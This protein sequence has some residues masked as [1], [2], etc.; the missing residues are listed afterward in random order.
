MS[1]TLAKFSPPQPTGIFPRKRLFSRLDIG[2]DHP[3]VW[4]EGPPGA[5][6]TVLLA[7]YLEEKAQA[8]LWFRLEKEDRDP[9]RFF[10]YLDRAAR[11]LP[12]PPVL[13]SPPPV[14]EAERE[15]FARA[16]L[17]QLF[18][19]LPEGAAVV[20]DNF[21]ELEEEAP[22]VPLL[23]GA[24]EE[25]PRGRTVFVLS[26][27]P[28]PRHFA[29]AQALRQL[30][31]I[32][33]DELALSPEETR[34]LAEVLGHPGLT[35]AEVTA[36]HEV[37]RGW[38]AGQVL[39]LEH[40]ADR[41]PDPEQPELPQPLFDFFF[42]EIF[43]SAPE[44]DRALLLETA[45]LPFLDPAL[46]AG[47]CGRTGGADR[48]P[49]LPTR[50]RFLQPLGANRYELH[51]L[52]RRFL[53]S[54]N[55]RDR[56]AA[57]LARLRK[58]AGDLLAEAGEAD[59]AADLLR[60][61]GDW[62]GLAGLVRREAPLLLGQGRHRTLSEWLLALPDRVR[63]ADPW[64][65][66]WL[67][68]ARS[69][70]Q[71]ETAI[72]DLESAYAG[73]EA[74]EDPTGLYFAWSEI[75]TAHAFYGTD[76]A[77]LDR[78][79]DELA[80]L[81][82]RYPEIPDAETELR[83]AAGA[84]TALSWH[85]PDPA[86]IR[87]WEERIVAAIHSGP[88]SGQALMAA[89]QIAVYHAT[90]GNVGRAA[91]LTD[92]I[93]QRASAPDTPVMLGIGADLL[94]AILAQYGTDT[95]AWMRAAERGL[96]RGSEAGIRG[97][98]PA[99]RSLAVYA[100]LN[101]GDSA[102]ATSHLA[103]FLAIVDQVPMAD[104]AH[105]HELKAWV[106]LAEGHTAEA[107]EQARLAETL[108]ERTGMPFGEAFIHLARAH[109]HGALGDFGSAKTQADRARD[110]AEYMDS[111]MLRQA[112][113]L[114]QAYLAHRRGDAATRRDALARA[115]E[116]GARHGFANSALAF[117]WLLRPLLAEAVREGICADHAQRILRQRGFPQ[118]RRLGVPEGAAPSLEIRTLGTFEVRIDGQPLPTDT[119]RDAKPLRLLKA[120]IA[121][122][123]QDVADVRLT[124][125]L[126]PEAEGDTGRRAFD[127]TLHR[128]RRRLGD[129]RA[130]VLANRKLSL[131]PE[132]VWVDIWALEEAADRVR[133]LSASPDK[134]AEALALR[135]E[136]LAL[137]H[138]PFL[139]EEPEAPWAEAHR[140]HLQGTVQT[141]LGSL[142]RHLEEAGR[143]EEA[144][145]GYRAGI[146]L[147]PLSEPLHRWLIEACERLG[148]LPEALAAYERYRRG[149]AE[150]W[151]TVPSAALQAAA[152]RLGGSSGRS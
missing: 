98:E 45:E 29:R 17:R 73:F 128:L 108:V 27:T 9:A 1:P 137:L 65:I 72:A 135:A 144:V 130:L 62:E 111:P 92:L 122:G 37:S 20:L 75:A 71:P 99:L 22:L 93:R 30:A 7:S 143:L 8:V 81:Q 107:L 76:L 13:P 34:G 61:A 115:L 23:G 25:I 110:L 125:T 102:L 58:R 10:H 139:P 145:E 66:L 88:L 12:D 33:P 28:P 43:Q 91:P 89:I 82:Q 141:L 4:V 119:G 84:A 138:G 11:S 51:P 117:P 83:V 129:R 18:A 36:L 114:S 70:F 38:A 118:P 53:R 52:F 133:D 150:A 106:D 95:A 97:P 57:E 147:A 136:I 109:A 67:G 120:L 46:A 121:F 35:E 151:G 42:T 21:Q 77:S 68:A 16:F 127:T 113:D 40:G 90:M 6:K 134:A 149:L 54:I 26:Q 69:P 2:R 3:L 48:L 74:R 50:Y 39:L 152:H 146:G 47:L 59:A 101:D 80:A 14:L 87:P 24:L 56:P 49:E 32:C 105:F 60:Q 94:E 85:R 103:E 63:G 124:D 5:G 131:D 104:R 64:L 44:E 148:Q 19:A 41:A 79:L 100:A 86:L 123:G 96:Q 142:G 78:W 15:G 112:C 126:W 31:R 116:L 55:E 132:R 140:A